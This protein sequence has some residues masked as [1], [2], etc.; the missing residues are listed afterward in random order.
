DVAYSFWRGL[1]QDRSSGPMWMLLE[2]LLGVSTIDEYPGDDAAKCQAVKNAVSYDNSARTVTFR[3]VSPF[4]PFLQIL[5]HSSAS[6]L[7][8]EWM[9]ANGDWSGDCAT[10]RNFYN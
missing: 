3:L 6:I 7:D 5:G 2:P 10:W 1:L 8:K 4:G 9:V